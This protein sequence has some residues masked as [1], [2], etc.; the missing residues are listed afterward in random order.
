MK[1]QKIY[2]LAC[3]YNEG[4]LLPFF[5]DYYCNFLGVSK[6]F[7]FDGGSTDDTA[8]IIKDYPVEMFVHKSDKMD[9]RQ[10]T[11]FRSNGWKP[12]REECDWFIVCDVDEFLYHQDIHTLLARYKSEGITLP[13]VEGFEMLSKEF[14]VFKKGDYLPGYIQ[15]GSP[16][17][18]YYNKHLIFDPKIDINYGLGSHRAQPSGPVKLSA[19]YDLKNLHH[20]VISYDYFRS[21]AKA[22]DDRISDWNRSMGIGFHCA[23]HANKTEQEFLAYFEPA[24]NIFEPVNDKI[25]AIP[26]ASFISRHLL[27][28]LNEYRLLDLS[29]DGR[30]PSGIALTLALIQ[31]KFGGRHIRIDHPPAKIDAHTLSG[32]ANLAIGPNTVYLDAAMLNIDG[33]GFIDALALLTMHLTSKARNRRLL[34]MIDTA[35]LD[36]KYHDNIVQCEFLARNFDLMRADSIILASLKRI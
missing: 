16:N 19:Q 9:E 20:K 26:L 2:L 27:S 7:L 5:L 33:L 36:A 18:D 32:I 14:P 31:K 35:S 10:L 29:N 34:L 11:D 23:E 12:W 6:I 3:S 13:L 1:T 24:D 25:A 15:L 8:E 21:K 4:R 30:Y 28:D 17:P 22:T